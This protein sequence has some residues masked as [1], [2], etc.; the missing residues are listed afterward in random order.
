MLFQMTCIFRMSERP[1]RTFTLP[2]VAPV[3]SEIT[4]QTLNSTPAQVR[5]LFQKATA[6]FRDNSDAQIDFWFSDTNL[7]KFQNSQHI[8]LMSL[9][10]E[11]TCLKDAKVRGFLDTVLSDTLSELGV[12][13]T[14]RGRVFQYRFRTGDR[15]DRD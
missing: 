7:Y 11:S 13:R 3:L 2:P 10:L 1:R 5:T 9:I 4:Q 8:Q 12:V 6:Y 15:T 14:L